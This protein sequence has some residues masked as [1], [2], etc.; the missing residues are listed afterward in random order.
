MRLIKNEAS[1]K[2]IIRYDQVGKKLENQQMYYESYQMS[3]IN[4]GAKVINLNDLAE[5]WSNKGS[6]PA[7]N[8]ILLTDD[9]SLIAEF[10]NMVFMFKGVVNYYRILLQRMDK[11]ADELIQVLKREYEIDEQFKELQPV[12]TKKAQDEKA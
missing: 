12:P 7:E 10:G 3:A 11:E 6:V 8:L 5:L 1:I 4:I 2:A 9:K